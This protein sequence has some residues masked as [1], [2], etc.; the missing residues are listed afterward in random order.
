MEDP[1]DSIDFGGYLTISITKSQPMIQFHVVQNQG[2]FLSYQGGYGG[3]RYVWGALVGTKKA[4]VSSVFHFQH[5]D[6]MTE[7]NEE[8]QSDLD[9]FDFR[10]VF[11]SSDGQY[12]RIPGRK[13]DLDDHDVLITKSDFPWARKMFAA[14]RNV[15]IFKRITKLMPHSDI[16]V[17]GDHPGAIPVALFEEMRQKFP[18]KTEL[19]HYANARVAAIVGDFLAPGHDLRGRFEAYVSKR[20]SRQTASVPLPDL[21]YQSEIDKYVLIRDTIATWLGE[22][23]KRSELDWQKMIIG[24]LPLIFPKYMAVLENIHIEDYYSE[25]GRVKVRKLD[26]GLV[27]ANGHLDVVE[28]KRPFDD[29]LLRKVLYRENYVPTGDLSGAIMQAEK[30]IFHLSKWG[31]AGEKKLTERYAAQLPNGLAIKITNPKA[32]LILG[33]DQKPEGGQ[34]VSSAALFDFEIIKRKYANMIDIITYDDLLRRLD[35]IIAALQH[36]ASQTGSVKP[37]ST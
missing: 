14:E 22:G 32:L 31:I 1:Q 16:Y 28:I 13:L 4:T 2:V 10:F 3:G 24:F 25:P 8:E 33:R 6:L 9:N 21:L 37:L 23:A 17:G 20:K 7:P 29:V 12:W 36:R 19:D 11:A 34:A 30:Y 15:S 27:D 26:L 18:N 5:L 35:C